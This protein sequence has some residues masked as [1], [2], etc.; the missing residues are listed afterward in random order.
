ML[1]VPLTVTVKLFAIV[2]G[3]RSATIGIGRY[4]YVLTDC[5]CVCSDD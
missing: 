3:P 2:T 5:V 4:G 1:Q